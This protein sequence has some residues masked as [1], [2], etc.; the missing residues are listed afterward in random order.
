MAFVDCTSLRRFKLSDLFLHFRIRCVHVHQWS[1][2]GGPSGVRK[3]SVVFLFP[4]VVRERFL[5]QGFDC[6]TCATPEANSKVVP[7][8]RQEE[9]VKFES[10]FVDPMHA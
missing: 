8:L 5:R 9:T 6:G 1:R 3:I 7:E 10:R 2:L 4:F